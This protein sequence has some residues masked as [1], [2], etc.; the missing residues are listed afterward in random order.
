M[1]ERK[2]RGWQEDSELELTNEP[3]DL[4]RNEVIE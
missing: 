3:G 1:A 4:A 2:G